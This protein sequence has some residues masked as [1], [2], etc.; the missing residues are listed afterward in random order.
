MILR[1]EAQK[2]I[3]ERKAEVLKESQ[4]IRESE[5][6]TINGKVLKG[7]DYL[8]EATNAYKEKHGKEMPIN[9]QSV[10]INGL[11]ETKQVIM[12]GMTKSS[13]M[14]TFVD[15]G[16]S[17]VTAILPNLVFEEVG[18]I[19]PLKVRTG[20]V[21]WLD[22]LFASTKGKIAENDKLFD[23]TSGPSKNLNYSNEVIEDEELALV[24]TMA[25]G[26]TAYTPIRGSEEIILKYTIGTNDYQVSAAVDL[27]AGT[28]TF[29]EAAT[30]NAASITFSN[31]AFSIQFKAAPVAG[32]VTLTYQFTFEDNTSKIAKLKIALRQ[33]SVT[34]RQYKL[35]SEYALDAA[36]DLSQAHGVDIDPLM[37]SALASTIRY[38]IDGLGLQLIRTQGGTGSAQV[39]WNKRIPLYID[40]VQHYRSFLATLVAASN[41][42]FGQTGM[43]GG[44]VVI[45]GLNV[46]N[47]IESM[48]EPWWKPNYANG[49][50]GTFSGP[51][52]AGILNNR[53]KVIKN[54]YYA[55]NEF[56]VGHKGGNYLESGAV[57]APY[58]PLY[59]T[60]AIPWYDDT[61]KRGMATSAAMRMLNKNL[62]VIGSIYDQAYS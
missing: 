21:F 40:Q 51:H 10:L 34:A 55:D 9:L 14:G 2:L 36:Y 58:R 13:D 33:L 25:S 3:A 47:I 24:G 7:S 28:C 49:E 41:I 53:W 32:S 15:Y 37:V 31:G 45:A 23:A 35:S 59:T 16:Y 39:T 6:G 43:V 5:F 61:V 18:S 1:E 46:M 26:N 38:E 12:E 30:I 57:L 50:M 11:K 27:T 56:V 19:Q 20:D 42:I 48:G 22:Y 4:L 60:P 17:L 54:P 52:V 29:T 8:I 44:N 62:F